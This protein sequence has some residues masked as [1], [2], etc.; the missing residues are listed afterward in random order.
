MLDYLHRFFFTD[1]RSPEGGPNNV[2]GPEEHAEMYEK[3][4]QSPDDFPFYVTF[5]DGTTVVA[6]DDSDE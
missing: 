6:F 5:V 4:M 1:Q 3:I 2:A